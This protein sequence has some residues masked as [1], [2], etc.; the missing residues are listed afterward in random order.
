MGLVEVG[1]LK[2]AE[3]Q[4]ERVPGCG[5]VVEEEREVEGEV[6]VWG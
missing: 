2:S 5:E 1:L 4:R 3:A 6:A